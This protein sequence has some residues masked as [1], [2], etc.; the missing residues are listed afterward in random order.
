MNRENLESKPNE[1]PRP[2]ESP[3]KNLDVSGTYHSTEEWKHAFDSF[4]NGQ[5]VEGYA[6][7]GYPKLVER[8]REISKLAGTERVLL[9]NDG[10]AAITAALDS[11][12]LN[13]DDVLLYSPSI[14]GQSKAYIEGLRSRGVKCVPVESGDPK[15]IEESVKKQKPKAIF[16]ETV[17]NAPDMPVVDLEHLFK[18]VEEE[19][20]EYVVERGFRNMLKQKLGRKSWAMSWLETTQEAELAEDQKEKLDS[21]AERFERTGRAIDEKHSLLPL[22]SL[23]RF[24]EEEGINVSSDRHSSLLEIISVI[25]SAWLAKREVP[26]TIILDNTIPTESGLDLPATIKKTKA[27]VLVAESG[28]KFFARDTATMGIVYGNSPERMSDLGIQR[29]TD[30]SYLPKGSEALL[31]T[32]TKEEFDS[33]NRDILRNTK[34][35]AEALAKKIG[36]A[37]IRAASYPNLPTHPNYEYASEKMPEGAAGV[38]YL[39]CDNAWETA[40]KLEK[41][42]LKGKVEYGASFGFEKTRFGVFTDDRILRIAGGNESPEEILEILKVI[43]SL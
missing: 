40:K 39:T 4:L 17:G 11:V 7:Y 36:R 16:M 6:R 28:T 9:Y 31:P 23:Y 20:E 10:M 27:P 35:L 18:T 25:N 37:G 15:V 42:G 19:N 3:E 2:E 33:R 14:Y 13:K 41:A 12:C 1:E 21:L 5:P 24:L 43:E 34:T 30:G 32:I 29:A 8:E 38:L 22:R 26:I